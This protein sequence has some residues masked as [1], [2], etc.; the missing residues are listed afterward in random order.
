MAMRHH[1]YSKLIGFL[2]ISLPLVALAVLGTVFLITTD[3]GFDPGFTFSP[4]EF[5]ALESGS[6]LDNPRINGLTAKGDLFRLSADRIEPESLD[7]DTLIA[8]NLRSNIE[9]AQGQSVEIIADTGRIESEGELLVFPDGAH[10]ITSDGYE[11][12]LL[13]LTA[14]LRSGQ[15]SGELIDV[16]GPLGQ[17]SAEIFH[18]TGITKDSGR[19]QVLSF[20][21]NVMVTLN[22][23]EQE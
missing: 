14:N 2:K 16:N 13:T 3:D 19:N 9:F 12:I 6:Y 1:T 21:K 7:L 11:G 10:I 17:I 4:A 8:T 15:I 23:Q 20:E 22:T 18:I 5:N